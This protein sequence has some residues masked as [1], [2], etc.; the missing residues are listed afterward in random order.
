MVVV[1]VK[2]ARHSPHIWLPW[3]KRSASMMMKRWC[4]FM[5]MWKCL[6]RRKR[7]SAATHISAR[8]SSSTCPVAPAAEVIITD[9]SGSPA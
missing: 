1:E 7:G 2:A 8:Q 6:P 5:K 3:K 9:G 4:T